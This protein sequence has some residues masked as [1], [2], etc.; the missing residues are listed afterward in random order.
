MKK[1]KKLLVALLAAT[2]MVSALPLSASA[3]KIENE[4]MPLWDNAMLVS[5]GIY[6]GEDGFGYAES[7]VRGKVGTSGITTTIYV[8]RVVNGEKEYVTELHEST[9]AG[10]LISSCQFVAI[11]GESYLAE[12]TFTVTK[13][14]SDEVITKS[15]TEICP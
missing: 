5:C 13:N 14:G 2:L 3:A 12:Y 8:Y 9:Q 15:D 10:S 7:T 4:V 11:S 6:Y 1:L